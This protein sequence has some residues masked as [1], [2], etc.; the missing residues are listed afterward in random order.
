MAMT[1]HNYR[2]DSQPSR[3]GSDISLLLELSVDRISSR[4][5]IDRIEAGPTRQCVGED[6]H[7]GQDD[8]GQQQLPV[9]SLSREM[10]SSGPKLEFACAQLTLN[11]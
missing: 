4:L 11:E 5:G 2:N 6:W 8:M 1:P 9:C 7:A 3:Y 10:T